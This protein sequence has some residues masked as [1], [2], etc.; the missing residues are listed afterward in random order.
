MIVT[1]LAGVASADGP[2]DV[3][4][5]VTAASRSRPEG[6]GDRQRGE[7]AHGERRRNGDDAV[8]LGRLAMRPPDA[9]L[10]HEDFDLGTD[11]NVTFGRGD[12]VLQLRSSSSRSSM[13]TRSTWPSRA[14]A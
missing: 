14:A 2:N 4:E 1:A 3:S 6:P 9:G 8:D 12:A 13:S 11:Q 7:R 10:V 5:S